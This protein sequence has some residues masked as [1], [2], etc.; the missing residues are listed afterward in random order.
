[1]SFE[2]Q[3]ALEHALMKAASDPA[4]RPA[5]YKTLLDADIFIVQHGKPPPTRS[6]RTWISEGETIQIQNI[7]HNGQSYLPMFSSLPRLQAVITNE[8]NY[9]AMNARE[10][11]NM[12]RGAALLLNPG[13]DYGKEFTP[14]E[15]ASIIDG[16]IWRADQRL[17]VQK[18]TK[19]LIG[20]PSRYP[21]ELAN[22]LSR[23][24]KT[25]KFV[26]RAWIAHYHNP[27]DGQK[28]HTIVAVDAT[29]NFD[30]ISGE[31][32]IVLRDIAIPDPP[33][34]VMPITGKGGIENYF[35]H[36]TAPFYQRKFLG[37]F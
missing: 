13:S 16:S 15:I 22:A 8:V 27:E 21:T 31:I 9:L 30:E 23:F 19:V 25:K 17:T 35:L 1:M 2:P 3:N 7:E 11:M 36:E 37:L 5:F 4:N 26:K 14:E 28:P 18:E 34:D 24:F 32:G 6:E 12:T 20:Q 29:G 10:F 33:V